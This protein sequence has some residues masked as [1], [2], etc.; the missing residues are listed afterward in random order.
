M[1]LLFPVPI[2]KYGPYNAN[3]RGIKDSIK[4]LPT[5]ELESSRM[6]ISPK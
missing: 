5:T 1:H 6:T 2:G 3:L 4:I